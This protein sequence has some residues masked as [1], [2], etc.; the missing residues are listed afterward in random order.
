MEEFCVI[1]FKF[2]FAVVAVLC[3]V[4]CLIMWQDFV[5]TV[6][7]TLECLIGWQYSIVTVLCT[8]ECPIAWQDSVVAVLCTLECLI[9]WQDSVVAVLCTLE[10][11][12]AWQNYLSTSDTAWS[13][14]LN[15]KFYIFQ[16]NI[17]L[18]IPSCE[19]YQMKT[20]I[21]CNINTKNVV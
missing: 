15:A 4:E 7:C 2:L 11:L 12:M 1:T 17:F 5:V 20:F 6:L 21:F 3:T 10:C 13:T 14:C 16:N 8:L 18:N 9:V 19:L